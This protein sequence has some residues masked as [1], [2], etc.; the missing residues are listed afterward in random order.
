VIFAGTGAT[1]WL[2]RR[3]DI[4]LM[5]SATYLVGGFLNAVAAAVLSREVL[6]FVAV[7]AGTLVTYALLALLSY[8]PGLRER[9]HPRAPHE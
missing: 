1:A 4:K 7:A 6:P 5:V 9:W 3:Q 8:A 2:T